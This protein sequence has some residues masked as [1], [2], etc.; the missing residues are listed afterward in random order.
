MALQEKLDR[1][2]KQQEKCQSM[3]SNISTKSASS[4]ST[5]KPALAAAA[6]F[7]SARPLK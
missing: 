1:F 2:K 3:L 7:P 5:P 4:R 6:P